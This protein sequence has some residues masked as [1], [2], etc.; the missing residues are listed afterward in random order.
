MTNIIIFAAQY[1]YLF[2]IAFF[3]GYG[4]IAN[5][6]KQFLLVSLFAL[7]LAFLLGLIASHLFYD[8]R[9]FM[10]SGIAPLIPHAAGNGFPSNHALLTGTLA[11]IGTAFNPYVGVAL[12]LLAFIVGI[13]RVI[14]NVHHGID[15]IGSFSIAIVSVVAVQYFLKRYTILGK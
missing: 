2:S 15:V 9:P 13:A 1:L 6:K 4:C 8:P 14:A 12:W 10:I 7:P 3:I 5:N 11:A